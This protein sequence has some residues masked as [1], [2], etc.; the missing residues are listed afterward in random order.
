MLCKGQMNVTKWDRPLLNQHISIK[1]PIKSD[2]SLTETAGL[3]ISDF[4]PSI[5]K[6]LAQD[7]F[8]GIEIK[9]N[10]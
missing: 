3:N 4:N 6:E 10:T 2:K 8:Y 1:W 5:E 7:F 9:L